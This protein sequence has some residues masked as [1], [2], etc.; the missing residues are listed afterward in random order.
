MVVLMIKAPVT[1]SNCYET[2]LFLKQF[3]LAWHKYRLDHSLCKGMLNLKFPVTVATSGHIKIAK[4][5]VCGL[6]KA[7]FLLLEVSNLG[8][9]VE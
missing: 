2:I 5:S 8:G 7:C 3:K 4:A 6:H 1:S 9:G